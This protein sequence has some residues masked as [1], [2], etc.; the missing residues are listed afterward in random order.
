MAMELMHFSV[1][2]FISHIWVAICLQTPWSV[3]LSSK[4]PS[5]THLAVSL[6]PSLLFS[7]SSSIACI[8]LSLWVLKAKSLPLQRLSRAHSLFKIYRVLPLNILCC[9]SPSNLLYCYSGLTLLICDRWLQGK[10]SRFRSTLPTT[11]SYGR[12]FSLSA[13]IIWWSTGCCCRWKRY[14]VSCFVEWI[15]WLW[16]LSHLSN[17]SFGRILSLFHLKTLTGM[18][19]C[20]AQQLCRGLCAC[21]GKGTGASAFLII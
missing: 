8:P 6:T 1:V 17:I 18:C 13:L 10:D 9:S 19:V 15:S 11:P 14:Y 12:N 4:T 20:A 16:L 2:D 3:L 5:P 21:K 7:W